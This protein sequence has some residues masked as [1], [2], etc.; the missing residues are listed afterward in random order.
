MNFTIIA[1]DLTGACD[2]GIQLVPYGIQPSV[3]LE[4]FLTDDTS[5]SIVINTD[6]RPMEPKA[7]YQTVSELLERSKVKGRETLLYKKIDSTMRG[8]I[9]A[10]IDAIYDYIRPDFV[11]IVPGHPANGRQIINGY[12]MLNR[13]ILQETEVS[14]DP[15]HPILS[16]NITELI[17]KQ[18]QQPIHHIYADSLQDGEDAFVAMLD[19]MKNKGINYIT[20]DSVS[21]QDLEMIASL[22]QYQP[23]S[24][25]CVG[26]AG[27]LS[28]LPK[29]LGYEKIPHSP[30]VERRSGSKLFIIGSVSTL[31]RRQ[32]EKLLQQNEVSAIEIDYFSDEQAEEGWILTKVTNEL[33]NERHIVLFSS[34][35]REKSQAFCDT[36]GK[37]MSAVGELIADNLG[38]QAQR[39]LS[40]FPISTLFLTGG[41]TAQKVMKYMDI[42]CLTLLDELEP[43]VPVCKVDSEEEMRVITKAGNFGTEEVMIKVLNRL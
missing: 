25:F 29:A 19:Q 35:D 27:L 43:G 1:D 8:N 26:S 2:T 23:Y 4:S 38:M 39:I 6:T 28:H 20:F 16:S 14:A 12:H 3:M 42:N 34:P 18:S 32:L 37:S 9:G 10:E 7:A 5:D 31:G 22:I 33:A 41:E 40:R 13:K 15:T 17:S 30:P 21:E 11:F 36:N 24:Y